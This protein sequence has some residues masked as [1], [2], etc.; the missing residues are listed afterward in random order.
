[1]Q[2]RENTSPYFRNPSPIILANSCMFFLR[3]E[4]PKIAVRKAGEYLTN[5]MTDGVIL[6][7]PSI[8]DLR[9][10]QSYQTLESCDVKLVLQITDKGLK[11]LQDAEHRQLIEDTN[12]SVIQ[13]NKNLRRT[14]R[15]NSVLVG[16]AAL[17]AA[18]NL[19]VSM[20]KS[21]KQSTQPPTGQ[22]Q[23][24]Q[25]NMQSHPSA[26]PAKSTDSVKH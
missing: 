6:F 11:E 12:R 9:I 21:P 8:D 13:T 20:C 24:A 1:M 2:D 3:K 15:I 18:T 23:P 17:F 19:I 26:P 22:Y 25:K 16:L 5:M 4:F 14:N 10:N 7:H